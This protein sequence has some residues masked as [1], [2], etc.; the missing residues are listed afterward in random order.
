MIDRS[1]VGRVIPIA[2]LA[3]PVSTR[4]TYWKPKVQPSFG[5]QKSTILGFD[6]PRTAQMKS[7]V[8]A[9]GHGGWE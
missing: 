4:A 3:S 9:D 7:K 5:L 2:R 6:V 8:L 1:I